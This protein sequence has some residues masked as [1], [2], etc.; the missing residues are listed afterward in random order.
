MVYRALIYAPGDQEDFYWFDMPQAH[1]IDVSLEQIPAGNDYHLYLY[2]S[3]QAPAGYSGNP[4]NQSEYISTNTLPAGRY[5][6]RV[7]RVV[8]YS[9]T[10]PYA[11]RAVFR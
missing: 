6:V 4:G 2:T 5:Y 8:G 9:A 3:T 1:T 11:L 7:Q 10:Q